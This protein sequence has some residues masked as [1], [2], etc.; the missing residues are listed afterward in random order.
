MKAAGVDATTPALAEITELVGKLAETTAAL[1]GLMAKDDFA[2]LEEEAV[3]KTFEIL[4]SMLAV[5][6]VAD[7]MEG[8]VADDLWPL[9]SY[10]E[11]LFIK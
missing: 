4:P 9:P 7:T 11:V 6:E 8:I 2:S 1:E 5:R 3:Y 10:Q